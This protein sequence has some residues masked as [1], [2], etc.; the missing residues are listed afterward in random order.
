M[1]AI[2]YVVRP[3]VQTAGAPEASNKTCA[4]KRS[5]SCP[6]SG[7]NHTVLAAAASPPTA[8]AIARRNGPRATS[9]PAK[10]AVELQNNVAEI[11]HVAAGA[12]SLGDLAVRT[13]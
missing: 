5:L 2:E 4:M 8:A 1:I 12:I 3:V 11:E 7:T 13:C 6:E 9:S 10:R